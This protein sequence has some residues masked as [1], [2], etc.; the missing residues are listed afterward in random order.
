M[1]NAPV[2]LLPKDYAPAACTLFNNMKLPAACI[3]AGQIS[4]GFATSFPELP[5]DTHERNYSP[6]LRDRCAGLKR[7]HVVLALIS[8][9]S[10][11]I[12]V[13]WAAVEVN[14]LTERLFDPALSVWDLIQRDC[15]LA[16]SAVNTHFVLGII[17]FVSMLA[18]RAYVM[19]ISASASKELMTSA[20]TGT[21]AALCLMLSIVNRGVESGGGNGIRYG[22]TIVD[23]FQHYV[24][25]LTQ[26]ALNPLDPGP[27]QLSAVILE[28]ASL[29]YLMNVLV[30]DNGKMDY[31]TDDCR[32]LRDG[33]EEGDD[34]VVCASVIDVDPN[35]FYS[36]QVRSD[37]DDKDDNKD[38]EDKNIVNTGLLTGWNEEDTGAAVITATT[39][40]AAVVP[41]TLLATTRVDDPNTHTNMVDRADADT[42]LVT[43]TK[44]NGETT[45]TSSPA[46]TRTARPSELA[47]CVETVFDDDG[48]TGSRT[49]T[50]ESMGIGVAAAAT[51]T[52]TALT[53]TMN[54]A[55]TT[56]MSDLDCGEGTITAPKRKGATTDPDEFRTREPIVPIPQTATTTT[57]MRINGDPKT[58]FAHHILTIATTPTNNSSSNVNGETANQ[59]Q[60]SPV[61]D[62]RQSQMT[63]FFESSGFTNTHHN[64][65]EKPN[66]VMRTE[67]EHKTRQ[68][69]RRELRNTTTTKKTRTTTETKDGGR[70]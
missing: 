32:L 5:L 69:H 25:L 57:H 67:P 6:R 53:A 22:S 10:E 47:R 27:L 14:Q 21:I 59:P 33:N 64:I 68:K 39:A 26:Q 46:P 28:S 9:T 51:T 35:H 45:R 38:V 50:T 44:V 31:T 43:A 15:D 7:L 18:L 23:L 48:S 12:V 55:N 40:T 13:M 20:S 11:L 61:T 4:L 65:K 36:L 2:V 41:T 60:S 29:L 17:G 8:I 37:D 34:E 49:K 30:L 1:N 62:P 58:T 24:A 19:L 54:T 63:S 56:S 70:K 16:W 66:T 42:V 3:T 52:A